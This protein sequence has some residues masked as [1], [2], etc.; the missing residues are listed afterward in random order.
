MKHAS[1][2]IR[3]AAA[4]LAALASQAGATSDAPDST[5]TP[6]IVVYESPKAEEEGVSREVREKLFSAPQDIEISYQIEDREGKLLRF[7]VQPTYDRVDELSVTFT[8]TLKH[9]RRLFPRLTLS[10]TF[11]TGREKLLYRL[12]FEQPFSL[13]H[14]LAL[15]FSVFDETAPFEDLLD[16]VGLAENTLAALFFREDFRH[17]YAREGIG[18]HATLG[19][20]SWPTL[21]V[22]YRDEEH[23]SLPSTTNGSLFR[24]RTSFRKNPE[25][26][27][28]RLRSVHFGLQYS[29]RTKGQHLGFVHRHRLSLETSGPATG[30]DFDFD[31]WRGESNFLLQMGPDQ[32]LVVRVRAGGLMTGTLPPQNRFYIGGIGSLRG[33][34]F[35]TV[36]GDR[37]FLTNIEYGFGVFAGIQAV[38]FQDVGT[39]W[40]RGTSMSELRPEFDAGFALRNRTERFRVNFARNLR[41]EQAPIIVTV[42][43]TRPF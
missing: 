24:P 18:A 40:A 4:A 28:G 9:A 32:N 5:D 1:R 17:Y 35:S 2:P 42:R 26:A 8:E 41:V 30:S 13:R 33:H 38:V 10:E 19:W 15:G 14:R 29:N 12:D 37:L 6:I 39:A 34:E 27:E 43:V 7:D 20:Q 21:T 36:S 23:A 16:R 11:S 3:L 31:Q 25:A 22:T